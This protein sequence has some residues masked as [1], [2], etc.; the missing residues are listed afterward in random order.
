[1]EKCSV[2]KFENLISFKL[3]SD[4]SRAKLLEFEL[5]KYPVRILQYQEIETGKERVVEVPRSKKSY[6]DKINIRNANQVLAWFLGEK[7]H[8]SKKIDALH[9]KKPKK[10]KQFEI[11][12]LT[13]DQESRF[14]EFRNKWISI[15][16]STE[17]ADRK[18]AEEGALKA[19]EAARVKPPKEFIWTGSPLQGC[20]Q[21]AIRH[22]E[23]R[24][25]ALT[26]LD[27]NEFKYLVSRVKSKMKYKKLSLFEALLAYG[28]ER[29]N[30][31]GHWIWNEV[32]KQEI[33][34]KVKKK[35][36]YQVKKQILDP[37]FFLLH[38]KIFPHVSNEIMYV[39]IEKLFSDSMWHSLNLGSLSQIQTHVRHELKRQV[40]KVSYCNIPLSALAGFD[41]F[42]EVCRLDFSKMKGWFEIAQS[43]FFWWWQFPEVVIFSERPVELH[44]DEKGALHRDG[45]AAILYP[46]GW[47]IYAWH[48]MMI[49]KKFVLQ[50]PDKI[51]LMDILNEKNPNIKKSVIEKCGLENLFR[52]FSANV[53]TYTSQEA[54]IEFIC[55]GRKVRAIYFYS[56]SIANDEHDLV[57]IPISREE[58][59]ENA[60]LDL[61]NLQQ[62]LSWYLQNIKKENE[63]EGLLKSINYIRP[64]L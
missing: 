18:R 53:I 9:S 2:S 26:D 41:Y 58:Y 36:W 4:S 35:I 21:A 5:N 50:K 22:S 59:G 47:G 55:G 42:Q 46:D 38:E 1:M 27:S 17:P 49:P 44:L 54:L 8:P 45:G 25:I 37:V 39:E 11:E 7:I 56:H 10:S 29:T 64:D 52:R 15:G 43:A 16:L 51:D 57:Q 40:D 23:S 30:Y 13:L 60:P 3:I 33:S 34:Q 32:G 48:G 6:G 63:K 20:V 24:T 19:Y 12:R 28:N 31:Y 14:E 62:V 61:N